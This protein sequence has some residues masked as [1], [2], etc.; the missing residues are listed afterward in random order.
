MQFVQHDGAWLLIDEGAPPEANVIARLNSPIE[1][2]ALKGVCEARIANHPFEEFSFQH[3]GRSY[4][5]SPFAD[6]DGKL[7]IR[8]DG[9]M[10]QREVEESLR[11]LSV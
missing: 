9:V 11:R 10:A 8:I 7:S 4:R 6:R 1:V 5:V 3:S 2:L